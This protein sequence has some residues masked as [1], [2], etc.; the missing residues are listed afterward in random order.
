[1]GRGLQHSYV[2]GSRLLERGQRHSWSRRR[3][4]LGWSQWRSGS[5]AMAGG[6]GGAGPDSGSP[7]AGASGSTF[8]GSGGTA[9]GAGAVGN[10][11]STGLGQGLSS[12]APASL[13]P[14]WQFIKS[15]VSGAQ[16]P[17]FD[18]SGWSQVSTPHTY[19]D[20][21]SYNTLTNH[22]SGDTGTYQG[23]AWYRKHFKIPS[24][25]SGNK[26]IIEFE[27]IKQGARFYINGAAVG[28]FDDGVTACGI[29]VTDKVNFGSTENVLAARV[30][31]SGNYV[32]S[33]TGVG[34]EWQGRAF[35]PNFGGI[36]VTFGY[37]C[38]GKSIKRFRSTTISRRPASTS[39]RATSRT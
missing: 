6:A 34:F 23:P 18:D 33:T 32:E 15:D 38:R 30:D 7:E 35:N 37:I 19:N 21:D 22:G 17:A 1:M 16:A 27:R 26:V 39:T 10:A 3:G 4:R 14:G 25:Y 36:T 5:P 31:N 29:D 20:V 13:D 12:Y 2:L 24:S 11:G 9:G 8:A 28:V